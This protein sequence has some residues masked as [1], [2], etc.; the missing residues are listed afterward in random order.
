L[1]KI[2]QGRTVIIYGANYD[3]RMMEQS[4]TVHS[5]RTM[6]GVKRYHCAMELYAAFY[7]AWND[8]RSSY[9][10]QKL[11]NA[12]RQCGIKIPDDLHRARA[13]TE[14]TRQIVRYMAAAK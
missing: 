7:G 10:W 2:L 4:A 6:F 12:A 9:T 11:G 5:A 8:Y 13:D 3:T 14:L 1:R